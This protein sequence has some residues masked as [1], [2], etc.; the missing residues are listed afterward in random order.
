ML[1]KVKICCF[2]LISLV[3]VVKS[4][5][6]PDDLKKHNPDHEFA[7]HNTGDEHDKQYDHE[8]ITK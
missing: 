2:L 7:L 8:A 1:Y 4:V 3:T 5:P 6:K